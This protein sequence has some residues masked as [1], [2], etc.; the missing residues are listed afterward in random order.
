MIR[1]RAELYCFLSLSESNFFS[2]ITICM[3]RYGSFPNHAIAFFISFSS[4]ALCDPFESN[5]KI[6]MVYIFLI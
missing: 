3:K 2:P 5:I 6:N 4:A 1:V